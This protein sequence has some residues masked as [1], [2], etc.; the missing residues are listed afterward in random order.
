MPL[1]ETAIKNA[2][3]ADKPYKMTDEKAMYL[4]VNPNG[5]KYFR[6]NYL[7]NKKGKT[8]A[9]GT[10][11]D[12]SLKEAREKRDFARKQ[13]AEGIDPSFDRKLK[14]MG[15]SENN[16]QAVA[17]EWFEK[18]I[19][20]KSDSHKVRITRL[21]ERDL[22][23]WLGC[24]P[25]AEIKT[26]ELLLVVQRIEVRS[27]ET[28]KRALQVTG[29]VFRYAE[30]TGRAERDITQSLKGAL[31]PTKSKHLASMTEPEKVRPLLQSIDEYSG[32]FVVKSAFQLAPLVFVRPGELRQA[33]WEHINFETKEWRYLVTKTNTPHIVPL[34]KQAI[35]I[36]T[37]L[38]PLT[39]KGRYVFPSGRVHN[40]SRPLSDAALLAAL[41]RMGYSKEEMSIHGFR[42][43]AR[44]MLDEKLGFRPDFIEHQLAHAIR[45]PNGRAYNRTSHLPERHKMMQAW[46]D[47]L[48]NLKTGAV[49]IP[50]SK[51]A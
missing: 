30:A 31:P 14:K 43:M 25:I 13:I 48:D 18:H 4:L 27:V 22:F 45:D 26:H 36:L 46:S 29:Q 16:F 17:L 39:G 1:T 21:F 2:K 37:D 5:G 3:S 8:L 49:I 51:A 20:D 33:E 35:K 23:P 15:A 6:L 32:S 34:S 7:F 10:Y 24:K 42:A 50:F 12:T 11:P 40:G 28:A 47:Y 19:S 38:K 44:T 41:R 9:L